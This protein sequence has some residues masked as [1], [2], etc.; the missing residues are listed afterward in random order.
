MG[1]GNALRASLPQIALWAWATLLIVF[2]A[3]ALLAVVVPYY[4]GG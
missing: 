2:A 3:W 4:Y 1:W